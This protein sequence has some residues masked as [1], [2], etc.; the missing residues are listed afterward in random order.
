M[1]ILPATAEES[2]ARARAALLGTT[3]IAMNGPAKRQRPIQRKFFRLSFAGAEG[4]ASNPA[5]PLKMRIWFAAVHRVEPDGW[6]TFG[7]GELARVVSI[8]CDSGTGEVIRDR[9]VTNKLIDSMVG[10]GLLIEG[11]HLEYLGIPTELGAF[12]PEPDRVRMAPAG[13]QRAAARGKAYG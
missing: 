2:R 10:D 1:T 5:V 7:R 8:Q 4:L 13:R 12:G 6:A 3:S 11:S 9:H